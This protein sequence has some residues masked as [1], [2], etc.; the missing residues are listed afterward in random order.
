MLVP[1]GG[2]GLAGS[3]GSQS[4]LRKP[5]LPALLFAQ[6]RGLI[7]F[8]GDSAGTSY[9]N[10]HI[11]GA[12]RMKKI[13]SLYQFGKKRQT[14]KIIFTDVYTILHDLTAFYSSLI[15][16]VFARGCLSFGSGSL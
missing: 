3:N 15:M 13:V 1:G 2:G 4:G 11:S 10:F 16:V 14:K 6:K 9:L 8:I 12:G 7:H 5:W